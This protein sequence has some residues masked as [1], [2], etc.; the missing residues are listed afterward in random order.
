MSSPALAADS[1]PEPNAAPTETTPS[2]AG[3]DESVN[4]K[5][6]EEAGAPSREPFINTEAMGDLWNFILLLGGGA[7]GFI[8][9]RN[10]NQLFGRREAVP[11]DPTRKAA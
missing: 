11:P 6:A 7:A 4:E 5:M 8:I 3:M 10:W 9:G 1:A 2:F